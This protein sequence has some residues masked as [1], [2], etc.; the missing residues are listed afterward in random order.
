M[1]DFLEEKKTKPQCKIQIKFE[2]V[3]E[4]LLKN[5]VDVMFLQ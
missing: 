3:L 1:L 4:Y 5:N 2:R